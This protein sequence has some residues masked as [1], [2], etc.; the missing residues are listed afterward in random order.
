MILEA[1]SKFSC[2]ASATIKTQPLPYVLYW[3]LEDKTLDCGVDRQL[4]PTNG[5]FFDNIVALGMSLGTREI[6]DEA[7]E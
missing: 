6:V 1:I 3:N 7:P 2:A 4:H 5:V